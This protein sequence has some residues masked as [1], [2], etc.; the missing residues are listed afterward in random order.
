MFRNDGTTNLFTISIAYQER[1]DNLSWSTFD[2]NNTFSCWEC[3]VRDINRL[4]WNI[5]L[6]IQCTF[7]HLRSTDYCNFVNSFWI[8]HFRDFL[9]RNFYIVLIGHFISCCDGTRR[10]DLSNLAVAFWLGFIF[11]DNLVEVFFF[12]NN[13]RSD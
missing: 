3:I 2:I 11:F 13:Y 8:F 5:N 7:C 1:T 12:D 6:L 4:E 9:T 10:S